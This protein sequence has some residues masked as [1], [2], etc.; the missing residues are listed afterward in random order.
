MS[1]FVITHKETEI[2]TV[3]G[4][5]PLLVGAIN[6]DETL[7]SKYLR[8]DGG[9]NIS[10]YNDSYCEMTG[11]YWIWKNCKD[12]YVGVVHYRRFF[13]KVKYLCK[14]KSRYV[15]AGDEKKCIKIYTEEELR[16]L[17]SD[18]EIIVKKSS[19]YRKGNKHIFNCVL[20]PQNM[21]LFKTVLREYD[22][23]CYNQFIE[24]ESKRYHVNCNMFYASKSLIDKYCTWLFPFLKKIDEYQISGGAFYVQ[25][26]RIFCRN[27]IWSLA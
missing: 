7:R 2:P 25:R 20:G 18:C 27:C 17:L 4:Y 24:N 12:K 26:N 3:R 11:L 19:I 9:E 6:R 1:V 22:G 23:I 10:Q 16:D 13:A 5:L 21:T 8:D 14:L 15:L